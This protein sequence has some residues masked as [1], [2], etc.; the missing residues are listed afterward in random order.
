[1]KKMIK[2]IIVS[3]LALSLA[4]GTSVQPVRAAGRVQTLLK[5]MGNSNSP[6]IEF[7]D[8]IEYAAKYAESFWGKLDLFLVN[9][10]VS[11]V[12]TTKDDKWNL[13]MEQALLEILAEDTLAKQYIKARP[14]KLI[15][16][17]KKTVNLLIEET[18]DALLKKIKKASK[19]EQWATA[20]MR[21]RLKWELQMYQAKIE[22]LVLLK[23]NTDDPNLKQ[24]CENCINTV[25]TNSFDEIK[26]EI[27]NSLVAQGISK[28]TA[29]AAIK[30]QILAVPMREFSKN[31]IKFLGAAA[32]GVSCALVILDV[33]DLVTLSGGVQS[34]TDS[35]MKIVSDEVV[36]NA[37]L[38]AYQKMTK[39]YKKNK[40][41]QA[42]MIEAL[43]EVMLSAKQNAYENIPSMMGSSGW[44]KA[45]REN[46]TLKTNKNKI[47]QITISNYKKKAP[48]R[49]SIKL[50]YSNATLYING[51]DKI[52]LKAT[53]KGNNS[54]IKWKSSNP[55]VATV[56]AKGK[57][58]AKKAGSATITA[59]CNGLTAKCKIKVKQKESKNV[60]ALY[61]DYLSQSSVTLPDGENIILGNAYFSIAD[62]D[63]NGVEELLVQRVVVNEYGI[64]D[65]SEVVIFTIENG[66]VHYA[67]CVWNVGAV[68]EISEYGG[69]Y[70]TWFASG[71]VNFYL[72][73]LQ[74]GVL[75]EKVSLRRLSEVVSGGL[76]TEYLFGNAQI[77]KIQYEREFE[78]YKTSLKKGQP[79]VTNNSYY[80]NKILG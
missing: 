11:S 61:K 49:T 48:K 37:A 5:N 78:K 36:Y 68:P 7:G 17:T 31:C 57:V 19:L 34:R 58:R 42:A 79:F 4:F 21:D 32:K 14:T 26:N 20:A 73:S 62:I 74:N 77:S 8:P 50:N 45:L 65:D 27:L 70:S 56:S 33:K 80:R 28:A 47:K 3:L 53:V 25:F 63:R 15:K 76:K 41:D 39:K 46:A 1:M 30:N 69:I 24:A 38:S 12:V 71:C 54:K 35:Y 9:W 64:K 60:K 43:F 59:K 13:S 67:G 66:I 72:Y 2:K 23:E 10:S 44:S 52:Q 75:Y 6:L 16:E 51:S 18:N 40:Q 29:K 22:I 55:K